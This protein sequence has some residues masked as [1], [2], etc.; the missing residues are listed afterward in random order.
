ML[1]TV[2][3][4]RASVG[5]DR[6][7]SSPEKPTSDRPWLTIPELDS[8]YSRLQMMPMTTPGTAQAVITVVRVSTVPRRRRRSAPLTSSAAPRPS[9]IWKTVLRSTK[10]K[11]I[12]IVWRKSLPRTSERYA[13]VVYPYGSPCTRLASVKLNRTI[14]TIG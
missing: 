3:D 6:N 2:T 1:A 8:V 7:G 14:S 5:S 13:S 11:V 4:A 10:T 9:R 12:S